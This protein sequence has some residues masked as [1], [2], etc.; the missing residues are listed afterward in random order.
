MH[1]SYD[2]ETFRITQI[3][4][5]REARGSNVNVADQ[6]LGVKVVKVGGP[7]HDR[8]PLSRFGKE[9]GA[10]FPSATKA[11]ATELLNR[12]LPQVEPNL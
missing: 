12:L 3:P 8:Y 11:P 10:R 2:P 6:A 9:E 5:S 1:V 7:Y 4:E